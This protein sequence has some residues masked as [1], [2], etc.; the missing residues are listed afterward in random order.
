LFGFFVGNDILA[1]PPTTR[2]PHSRD[3]YRKLGQLG[4][5]N[6]CK[7]GGNDTEDEGHAGFAKPI[8][9]DSNHFLA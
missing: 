1:K 2:C 5:S 6:S 9:K 8:G 3:G 7:L 4:Y